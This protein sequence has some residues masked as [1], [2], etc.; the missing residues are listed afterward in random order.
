MTADTVKVPAPLTKLRQVSLAFGVVLGMVLVAGFVFRP[1]QAFRSYLLAFLFWCGVAVG[2][3]GL[4]MIQ[5]LT[6]GMWG[7]VT[8]RLLEAA[9]RTF[10]FLALLFVPVIL[11]IGHLYSWSHPDPADRIVQAKV[12]WLNPTFFSVRGLLYLGIWAL[13]AWLLARG[14]LRQDGGADN[15]R[16]LRSLSGGGLVVMALTVSFAAFDWAMS[17]NPHWFSSVYGI[18]FIISDLLCAV[19]FTVVL[20]ALLAGEAPFAAVARPRVFHDLGKLMLAFVMFWAYIAFSQFLII[21]SSNVPEFTPFYVTRL[22]GG[23]QWVALALIGLHFFLPF[24]MLLSQDLKRDRK[25]LAVVAGLVFVVR[26]IDLFWLVAPDMA[27]HGASGFHLHWLDPVALVAL[28]GL[29]LFVFATILARSPL[30]PL[31]EPEIRE[32]LEGGA[33]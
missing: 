18:L 28:G 4:L 24:L 29:W 16:G 33:H 23:W 31:G 10:P 5:H 17:L 15:A 13:L 6:G 11:G 12:V 27:G 25:R 22:Q 30:L 1:T 2:S 21:W 3:T 14:S 8:R 26:A 20:L 9:G 7:M 19:A 32:A